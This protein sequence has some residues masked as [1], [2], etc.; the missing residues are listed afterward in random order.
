MITKWR[1]GCRPQEIGVANVSCRVQ[2][3]RPAMQRG[4]ENPGSKEGF[5]RLV[6]HLSGAIGRQE[7]ERRPN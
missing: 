5:R 6:D 7:V 2:P 1:T 3:D 4:P